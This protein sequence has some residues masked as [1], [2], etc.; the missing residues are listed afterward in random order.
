VAVVRPAAA[1]DVPHT[2]FFSVLEHEWRSAK[3]ELAVGAIEQ[4]RP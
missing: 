1:A 2:P 4:R 3:M